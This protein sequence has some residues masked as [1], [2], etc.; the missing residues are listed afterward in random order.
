MS[1]GTVTVSDDIE[2][3]KGADFVYTDVWYGLYDEEEG[4]ESYMDVFYP[5]YQVT[6]GDD[7]LRRPGLQVHCTACRPPAA[8]K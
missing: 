2:C 6:I 3:I 7:G 4:G 8:R 1:G 5:K